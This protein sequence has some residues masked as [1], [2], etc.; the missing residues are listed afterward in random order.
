MS[1]GTSGLSST[2]PA[3]AF[4]LS[5][6]HGGTIRL[7]DYRQRHPVLLALLHAADCQ[8]CRSWLAA[9]A[10]RRARL[11]E[12]GAAVLIVMPEP[13]AALG[14]LGTKL[15]LPFPLL[16]DADGAVAARY[17]LPSGESG[18]AVVAL[19]RYGY[20]I[21]VWRADDGGALPPPDAPLDTIAFAEMEDC[22]CGLPAWPPEVM[23]PPLDGNA[24]GNAEKE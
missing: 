5:A 7:A 15:D 1:T 2:R 16:S 4:V 8:A 24:D 12:L 21:G 20:P 22:G 13:I 9:L 18:V 23:A 10:K 11:D 19:N 17:G 6:T 3:P 14:A